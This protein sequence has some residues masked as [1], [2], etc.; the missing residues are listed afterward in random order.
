[1]YKKNVALLTALLAFAP[2]QSALAQA[3][4]EVADILYRTAD[5]LGMLRTSREVDRLVTMVYTGT[6]TTVIDG[7]GCEM[8]RYTASVRYPIPDQEHTF[9]VPG[10]RVDISCTASAGD[11]ERHV[12]VVAG[13]YAW[14]EA[15]PG[16]GVTPAPGAVRERLLQVW[17][18]PQGL[19]KAATAAGSRAVASLEAG[20]PV[21]TFPLPAPLDDT[22]V[23]VTLDPEVFLYHTMPNGVRRGFS[24]RIA[25]I[26]TELDGTSIEVAYSDYRDWNAE[27]YKADV[28]LPG[29]MVWT[30]DGE[31]VLDLTL[32]ESNT[33]NP[34]VIM[35]V[36]DA[37][38]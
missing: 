36:P 23:K 28:L 6:G 16:I 15:T 13:D 9:P 31:T 1:M 10:M 25:Q 8:E 2:T 7:E 12:Q 24:H 26:E 18:L 17:L 14:N 11:A 27:D 33:Y 29:R 35:P 4:A 3:S 37:V 5:M 34:Y 20:N 19:V 32:S 38:R 22:S 30:R 21:L